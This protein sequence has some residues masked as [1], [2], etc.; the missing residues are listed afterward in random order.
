MRLVHRG[1]PVQVHRWFPPTPTNFPDV[2]YPRSSLLALRPGEPA[3]VTVTWDNWCDPVVK[4]RPHVPPS[5]FRFTL[6]NGGGHLDADYN[7]VAD[8]IAP[9]S[10]TTIGVSPFQEAHVPSGQPWP[11]GSSLRASLPGPT[12]HARRGGILRFRIVLRN[13]SQTTVRFDT[14]PAYEE[15][16]APAGKVEV[17]DLNCAAAHPIAPGK[18]LAFSIQLRVPE[19]APPGPNGLFWGLDAF[20]VRTPQAHARVL[21][22]G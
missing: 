22:D 4:G 21:I 18:E 3:A 7:A 12:V 5:S 8:C 20:G 13:V 10:P 6:P 1:G 17:H 19:K 11:G 15:Q 2:A 16:L 9:A 14:C